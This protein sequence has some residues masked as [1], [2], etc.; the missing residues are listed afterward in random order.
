MK[1][2]DS[3]I[4]KLLF[5]LY[6]EPMPEQE[7]TEAKI[8]EIIKIAKLEEKSGLDTV[9]DLYHSHWFDGAAM[10]GNHVVVDRF[11]EAIGV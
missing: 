7:W 3:E 11:K 10:V 9:R 5:S 8:R 1:R 4:E 2:V 6:H